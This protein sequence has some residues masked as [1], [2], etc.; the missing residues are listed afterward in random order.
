MSCNRKYTL[1]DVSNFSSVVSNA[2][3]FT[4]IIESGVEKLELLTLF[5]EHYEMLENNLD[6]NEVFP[7]IEVLANKMSMYYIPARYEMYESDTYCYDALK[8]CQ[9]KD[10]FY[11]CEAM[12][13]KE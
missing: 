5:I 1:A 7:K 3:E 8:R 4:Y 13:E 9:L 6:S 11:R 10:L 2:E 12:G